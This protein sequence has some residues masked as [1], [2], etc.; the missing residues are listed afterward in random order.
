MVSKVPNDYLTGMAHTI[1]PLIHFDF[2]DGRF[3][4]TKISQSDVR[5]EK[6]FGELTANGRAISPTANALSRRRVS[7]PET[8]KL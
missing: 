8:R 5:G 4:G 7:L 1:N 3:L 6:M 2:T